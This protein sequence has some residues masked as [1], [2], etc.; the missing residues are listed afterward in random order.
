MP[1]PDNITADHIRQAARWINDHGIPPNRKSKIYD[2][3]VDNYP[4]PPKYIISVANKFA[5]QEELPPYKFTAQEALRYL[6]KRGFKIKEKK[7]FSSSP[8]WRW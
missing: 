4:Y 7:N 3:I 6:E 8:E 1:I 2:V 5:N